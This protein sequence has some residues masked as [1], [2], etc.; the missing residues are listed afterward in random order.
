MPRKTR[1][2]SAPAPKQGR[3]ILTLSAICSEAADH[4]GKARIALDSDETGADDALAH[5]DEAIGC[6]KRLL[7]YSRHSRQNGSRLRA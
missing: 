6:L 3:R 7:A 1:L 2:S 4:V 5:L